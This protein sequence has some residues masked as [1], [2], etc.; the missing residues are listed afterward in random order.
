MFY[1]IY[2][3]IG[4]DTPARIFK[5]ITTRS[6]FAFLMSFFVAFFIIP[7][8]I[9]FMKKIKAGQPIRENYL[10]E[11]AGKRGT[12]IM[13]GLAVM[14]AVAVSS[15]LFGRFDQPMIWIALGIGTLI[16]AVG[17]AD[18]YMKVTLRSTKGLSGKIRIVVEI[19][20]SAAFVY[21]AIKYARVT[22]DINIPFVW[23]SPLIGL[24]IWVY[25]SFA[26]LVLVSS[27][28]AANETD[29]IDGLA[30]GPAIVAAAV[31]TALCYIAG[32]K[33]LATYLNVPYIPG[34]G[35]LTLFAASLAGA[36]LAFL[37][38]NCSPASIFLGDT[39]SMFIGG[40]LGALAVLSHNELLLVFILGFYVLETLSV[41]LQVASFK[42]FKKRIFL[43]TPYHH[44]LEKK[45]WKEQQIAVRAWI[46]AILTAL[47]ALSSLKLRFNVWR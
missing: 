16:G 27:S 26:A 31:F 29:G 43:M 1:W 3:F 5:Y 7:R 23:K 38:Y 17:F 30:T 15:L 10:P 24:P 36:L 19:I 8:L 41:I 39:G 21:L 22:T 2:T 44:T 33:M 20:I 46:F 13:G 9:V 34:A 6:A 37:Y 11:H 32:N 42:L 12:P 47:I 28:H 25:I 4:G 40:S 35:E 14:A 45:G 18:D